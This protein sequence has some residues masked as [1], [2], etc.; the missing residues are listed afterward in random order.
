MS[1]EDAAN[2]LALSL[3]KL[4]NVYEKIAIVSAGAA[5]HTAA[6]PVRRGR[7]PNSVEVP[8]TADQILGENVQTEHKY[9]DVRDAVLRVVAR[10]NPAAAL[11]ALEKFGVKDAKALRPEQFGD[12]IKAL[13]AV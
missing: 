6:P 4:A 10:K 2:R 8:P 13:D 3:E 9:S 1:L 7:P 5:A 11:A 12:A